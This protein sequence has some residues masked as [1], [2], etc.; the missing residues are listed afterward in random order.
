MF[1]QLLESPWKS[2]RFILPGMTP[3]AFRQLLWHQ[4]SSSVEP[5]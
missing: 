5:T 2:V 4:Q 1:L 3:L